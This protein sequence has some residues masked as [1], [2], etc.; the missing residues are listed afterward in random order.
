MWSSCWF[1][2]RYCSCVISL[3]KI[4]YRCHLHL[5]FCRWPSFSDPDSSCF[6]CDNNLKL[7]CKLCSLFSYYYLFIWCLKMQI[8]WF[9]Y[10]LWFGYLRHER[11]GCGLLQSWLCIKIVWIPKDFI[12][13]CFK[14]RPWLLHSLFTERPCPWGAAT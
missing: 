2:T 14:E 7:C 8:Y 5:I 10:L 12:S 1:I 6:R 11:N 4:I 13:L 9:Q 3:I